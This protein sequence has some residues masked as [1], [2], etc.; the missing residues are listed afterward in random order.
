MHILVLIL[1]VIASTITII[2]F[3][4]NLMQIG[5]LQLLKLPPYEHSEK[6]NFLI[7]PDVSHLLFIFLTTSFF[8]ISTRILNYLYYKTH[9]NDL[10]ARFFAGICF[11]FSTTIAMLTFAPDLY[12]CI[13][14]WFGTWTLV[15]I[16]AMLQII[17]PLIAYVLMIP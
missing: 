3:I 10:P 13:H 2:G 14:S 1:G 16:V 8:Y 6:A 15:F 11:S 5:P 9:L 12:I 7:Y 4:S 17:Y